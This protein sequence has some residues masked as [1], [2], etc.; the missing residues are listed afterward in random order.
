M[1]MPSQSPGC[2]VSAAEPKVI[3]SGEPSASSYIHHKHSAQ[4]GRINV[5][6]IQPDTGPSDHLEPRS[7]RKQ[8]I[9]H[10]HATADDQRIKA[11]NNLAQLLR[12][13]A[14]NDLKIDILGQ[15]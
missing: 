9:I 5:Y 3:P 2:G 8:L 10:S 11:G 4:R 7:G 14:M 6:I 13:R 1:P 15:L 12:R